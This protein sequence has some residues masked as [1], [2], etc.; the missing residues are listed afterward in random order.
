MA[1]QRA[2]VSALPTWA[3]ARRCALIHIR[4]WNWP[5]PLEAQW[6]LFVPG[7]MRRATHTSAD[8]GI[9]VDNKISRL[10]SSCDSASVL[11]RYLSSVFRITMIRRV[12]LFGLLISLVS[13]AG[14]S[15]SSFPS[16][17]FCPADLSGVVFLRHISKSAAVSAGESFRGSEADIDRLKK[18]SLQFSDCVRRNQSL[19]S[20][21]A[22]LYL[23]KKK[24][25]AITFHSF[26]TAIFLD[27]IVHHIFTY[28]Q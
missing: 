1:S 23:K 17:P 18:A 12:Y 6:G 25:N 22:K 2:A 9:S 16:P 8:L 27:H 5:Q 14:A 10:V 24:R 11:R 3:C 7:E 13:S 20:I 19:H 26:I 28:T 21:I 15:L 4:V